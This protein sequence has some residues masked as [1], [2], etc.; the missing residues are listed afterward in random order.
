MYHIGIKDLK[1]TKISVN[2]AHVFMNILKM[3]ILMILKA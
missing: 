3:Q 2:S 1:Y